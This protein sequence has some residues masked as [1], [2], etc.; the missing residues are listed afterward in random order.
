VYDIS[1]SSM[2]LTSG[3]CSG[4]S[5]RVRLSLFILTV[6]RVYF[7]LYAVNNDQKPREQNLFS[8]AGEGIAWRAWWNCLLQQTGYIYISELTGLCASDRPRSISG[9]NKSRIVTAVMTYLK[10]D[11][12]LIRTHWILLFNNPYSYLDRGG[13][14]YIFRRMPSRCH[15]RAR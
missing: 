13:C 11:S 8:S 10:D 15:S 3:D 14:A 5:V 7:I 1:S 2:T 12:M 6:D 4:L 9:E